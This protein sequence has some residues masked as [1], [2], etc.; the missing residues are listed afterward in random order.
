MSARP[1]VICF[2]GDNYWFSNP[3]SRYHLMHA[4]RRRGHPILWVNSIG[5]NMP[6]V[7][8]SGLFTRVVLKLRSWGRWLGK[9]EPGFHVLTPIALPLFG[10]PF[11]ER[12]NDRWIG[13]QVGLARRLV[14]YGAPLVF[15]S[16]PSF[17]GVVDRL[18]HE[19]LIY[20]YSDKYAA[21]RDIT[22]RDSIAARDRRLFESA[23]A[24]FCASQP[25]YDSLPGGR[26]HVYVLPHAVDFRHFNAVVE[27]GA[28]E[29]GDLAGIPR[30]RVGY[31]GSLTSSNDQE[32]IR[33]A[34]EGAPD[35]HFVLIG[36]VLGDYSTLQSLPNVH[37]LGFKPYGELPGYGKHFDV[38]FMCWIMTDWIRH[39]NPLKTKEYLSMGLPV[40]SVRIE[41][42]EREFADVVYFAEDGREFLAQIRKALAEDSEDARRA[43][44]EAVRGESWDARVEE[45]ME[46]FAAARK[47]EGHG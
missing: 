25:I 7:R 35:L 29:P 45:M 8:R 14:G 43:R 32:M 9:A 19:G 42:L 39:S 3:H 12:V 23:D 47:E 11:L 38:A 22:A 2:A 10:N 4:L 34:A 28:P 41:Q 15:A 44:I 13:F 24:V 16:I 46:K 21:Y 1:P 31:F 5:M 36:R 26:D 17:A 6:K 20:Y 27:G 18:R 30:P 37:F 33:V 40:V